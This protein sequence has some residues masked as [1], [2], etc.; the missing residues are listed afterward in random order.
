MK[1]LREITKKLLKLLFF[2]S[3]AQKMAEE[4]AA[5]AKEL[6]GKCSIQ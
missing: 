4:Q 5:K 1:N 6:A 2:F 3:E